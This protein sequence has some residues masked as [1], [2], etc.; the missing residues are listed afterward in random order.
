MTTPYRSNAAHPVT[1]HRLISGWWIAAVVLVCGGKVC[2]SFPL[3]RATL[4]AVPA[5]TRAAT[6][7]PASL[8]AKPTQVS[9][10]SFA[11]ERV[12]QAQFTWNCSALA[13]EKHP[14]QMADA[15]IRV[16]YLGANGA[17]Q[18]LPTLPLARTDVR[19]GKTT[20]AVTALARGHGAGQFLVTVTMVDELHE[21]VEGSYSTTINAAVIS[22]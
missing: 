22:Q 11:C 17:V 12:S 4:V 2:A 16:Q 7:A 21:A 14:G 8:Y 15:E 1:T 20:A 10:W 5:T 9:R 6:P 3:G 13:S 19:A 18:C